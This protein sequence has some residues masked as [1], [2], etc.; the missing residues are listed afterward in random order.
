MGACSV[1]RDGLQKLKDAAARSTLSM[2]SVPL[3]HDASVL[4]ASRKPGRPRAAN[5]RPGSDTD[6]PVMGKKQRLSTVDVV[7]GSPHDPSM[8]SAVST[9]SQALGEEDDGVETRSL[10]Q[11]TGV[12]AAAVADKNTVQAWPQAQYAAFAAAATDADPAA[13]STVAYPHTGMMAYDPYRVSP[14]QF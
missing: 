5:K 3:L 8:L 9:P 14:R 13:A 12:T 2:P 4:P 1:L 10:T 7:T 11:H 6:S